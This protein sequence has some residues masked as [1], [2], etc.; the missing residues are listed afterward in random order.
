[1]GV[2]IVRP[3]GEAGTTRRKHGQKEKTVQKQLKK[4]SVL[5]KIIFFS[6]S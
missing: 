6:W 4:T 1:M 3:T 5:K 2:H